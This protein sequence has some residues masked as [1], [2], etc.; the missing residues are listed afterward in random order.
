MAKIS[1]LMIAPPAIFAGLAAL[2]FIGMNRENPDELPSMLIG[3]PAP[4]VEG[5]QPL[6]GTPLLTDEVL[7]G[8]GIKLVNFWGTWCVAC[9]AEHPTL[10]VIEDILPVTLHGVNFDDTKAKAEKYLA[11]DGNPFTTLG[12]ATTTRTKIDWG[13]YGAPETFI[14][15]EDGTVL[16]RFAGPITSRVIETTIGPIV[17]KALA[18]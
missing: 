11:E 17:A 7:Q 3:K 18:D 2:F 9:R 1:P 6:S 4:T 14:V 13:V 16:Y 5:L 10:L 12:E 8:P 15:D